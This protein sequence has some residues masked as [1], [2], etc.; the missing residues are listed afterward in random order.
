VSFENR[1]ALMIT[2]FPC[3]WS[4]PGYLVRR[5]PIA[6]RYDEVRRKIWPSEIA[7]VLRQYG[8]QSPSS[9]FDERISN[10]GPALKTVVRP[11]SSVVT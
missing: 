9:E 3:L 2:R 1:A 6:Q 7:T 8:E 10:F 5:S 4:G 11:S